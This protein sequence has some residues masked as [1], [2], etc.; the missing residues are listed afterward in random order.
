M[1]QEEVGHI[2]ARQ[3]LTIN[4]DSFEEKLDTEIITRQVEE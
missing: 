1:K 3:N 2:S 4:F